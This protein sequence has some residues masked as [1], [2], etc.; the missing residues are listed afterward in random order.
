MLNNPEVLLEKGPSFWKFA[1]LPNP[2]AISGRFIA[3]P[4][5]DVE[6]AQVLVDF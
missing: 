3:M 4:T 1:N 5:W 2:A 6:Q